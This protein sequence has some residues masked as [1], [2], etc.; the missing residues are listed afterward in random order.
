MSWRNVRYWP[1]RTWAVALQMSA[2]GRKADIIQGKADILP[3][4]VKG[5]ICL[6]SSIVVKRRKGATS[7]TR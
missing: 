1:K 6:E 3:C 4:G 7:A 2:F 5:R